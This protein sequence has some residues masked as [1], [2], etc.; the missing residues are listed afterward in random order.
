MAPCP[1]AALVTRFA[2]SPTGLLHLG[3]AFSAWCAWRR[4][5]A[6][7]GRLLLRIEDI[8]RDR[9]R[10]AFEAAILDDLAWL[11][12]DWDGPVRRQSDHFDEYRA[13]LARLRADG[14]LYPC[15]CTR[16]QIAAEIAAAP[17]APQGP[18]GPLYPGTCRA[19]DAALRQERLAAG[20]PHAWRLDAAAAARRLPR[21]AWRE[22]GRGRMAVEPLAL[23]DVVL[24]RKG[25]PASYH[26]AAC[27]DDHLQGVTLVVRG[28]D[29][30]PSTHVHRLL[31]ALMGWNEPAYAHHRLLAAADGR[32]LAKRDG[33]LSIRAL[34]RAG[35]TPAEVLALARQLAAGG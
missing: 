11:G 35:R 22:E 17:G 25:A 8:D 19:L 34:R 15:F 28:C 10:P 14:L 32:R 33:A 30:L 20:A 13:V 23:G 21:L 16:R 18:A 6:A 12:I 27:H 5:R 1:A 24:G 3:H 2:P 4:T 26:L 29:L 9:C 31:Q 7:G